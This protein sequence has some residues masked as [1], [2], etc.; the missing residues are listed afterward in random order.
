MF[1]GLSNF[2]K[3]KNGMWLFVIIIVLF[4]IWVLMS[5]SSSK[6]TISDNMTGGSGSSSYSASSGY[7]NSLSNKVNNQPSVG[8][9]PVGSTAGPTQVQPVLSVDLMAAGTFIGLD[10]IG[11]TLKNA[12]LQLRSDP[13]IDKR[14]VCIWNQSTIEPDLGR[15]PLELGCN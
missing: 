6:G 13:I 11:Q 7:S 12:N 5:Y 8:A 14:E 2:A 15:V 9:S 1:K 4:V 3:S 10:S